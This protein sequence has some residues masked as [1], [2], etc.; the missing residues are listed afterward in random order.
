MTVLH[1]AALNG[2]LEL[3]EALLRA[4]ADADSRTRDS[5]RFTPLMLVVLCVSQR[6]PRAPLLHRGPAGSPD[7]A[8]VASDRVG[9]VR[10]AQVLDRT[11]SGHRHS[12]GRRPRPRSQWMLQ[13]PL[14]SCLRAPFLVA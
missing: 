9:A 4:G 5:S 8:S 6:H 13:K 14:P 11:W 12:A 3:V 1:A 2:N 10:V 7:K